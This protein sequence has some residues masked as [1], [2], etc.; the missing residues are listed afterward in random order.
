MDRRAF[1][2]YSGALMGGLA[3]APLLRANSL[4]LEHFPQDA[5][6]N[7][8]AEGYVYEGDSRS[9]NR[10]PDSRG[11]AGVCVS[12]GLQVVKTDRNGKW[13]LPVTED[14]IL[15]VIKPAGYSVPV[16][17]DNLPQYFYI[18]KPKGSPAS[19]YGGV[20]PTGELPGSIDFRLMPAKES[21]Q[22]KM[23]MFGDPQ[24]RDQAEVDYIAHDV[25]EQAARDAQLH[26][27][28]FGIS[29]GDEM[30]D[31]LSLYDSLN[32]AIGTIGIPWYNTVG[33]HDMN[34]DSPDDTL[35]TE[36]FQ[37]HFGPTYYSFNYGE[38]HF[39]VLD[40][41]IYHGSKEGGY[42]GEIA[43]R[44]LEWLRN[45]LAMVP[46][47]H[48]V[49]IAM[50]IPLLSVQNR[51][52][53]FRIIEDRPNTVSVSAHTHVQAHYFLAEKDGWNGREPHH[54]IN[55]VTVCGSWWQ[56]APDERG[57][58]HATMSDGAPNGYSIVEFNGSDYKVTFRAASRPEGE[59]MSI[60]MPEQ[61]KRSEAALTEVIVNV[62]AAS[63]KSVVKMRVGDGEWRPMLNFEGQ[64][65]GYVKLKELEA[66]P[67]PPPGRKLP[68]ASMTKHL[69]KAPL[70][71]RL[72]LGT[73]A[74]EIETTDMFGHTYLDR[75]L[76]RIV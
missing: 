12:N 17:K 3:L 22:F 20:A 40:D 74:V 58:P 68:R 64:D 15:F 57:I 42:H 35:A 69:W 1:L 25:I 6:G 67:N 72:P 59:Q 50:H 5:E 4:L 8:F 33:N 10:R 28:A 56:G 53:L 52:D 75:R 11:I 71:S 2:K 32:G 26:K 13:R 66:G 55:N 60:W 46:K 23:L 61:V 43:K 9:E 18:H 29:L 7:R 34:Y 38:V 48:L 76:V 45:D 70:P 44:Q 49:F 21:K 24:P 30:F 41:V 65:P 51:Q 36:T 54:H 62:F 63:T 37:R 73:H 19:K 14:T 31:V 27:P 39:V 47:N 16:G